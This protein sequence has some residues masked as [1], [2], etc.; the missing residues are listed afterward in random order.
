MQNTSDRDDDIVELGV[1][2]EV[3]LGFMGQP[4]EAL[5]IPDR[6]DKPI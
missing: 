3:T 1:A 2:T 4:I 6:Q 5:T